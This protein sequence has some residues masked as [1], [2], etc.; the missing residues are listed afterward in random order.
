MRRIIVALVCLSPTI[1]LV[2]YGLLHQSIWVPAWLGALSWIGL[3]AWGYA[4]AFL[5]SR[6]HFAAEFDKPA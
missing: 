1:S 6:K 3:I 4:D 2:V 5:V